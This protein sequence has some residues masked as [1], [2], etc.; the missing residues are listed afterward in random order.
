MRQEEV[1]VSVAGLMLRCGFS[2]MFFG[3]TF[4]AFIMSSSLF[5]R[6]RVLCLVFVHLSTCT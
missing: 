3:V 2:E 1:L 6:W 4:G 5:L